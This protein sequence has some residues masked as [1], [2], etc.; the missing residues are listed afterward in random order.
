[1]KNFRELC[2]LNMKPGLLF[3]SDLLY[4]LNPKE[5]ALL[6]DKSI[7]VVIDLRNKDEVERL[8]DTNIKAIT[9]INNPLLPESKEGEDSPLKTVTIKHM[10]LPDMDNAYRELVR[11]DR[12]SA[13]SNIFN[14]LLSTDG[15]VLYHCSAGKDRTGVLSAV[16]LTALGIDKETIYKDYL[17][18]NEKP[19]Y[20]K[21][22][23]LEMD[24]ESREIFLDYFQAKK[25]YLDASFDEINKIYGSFDKFLLECCLIDKNKL[26][27]LKDKYLKA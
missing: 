10:T 4:H 27:I 3:R 26:D 5:K 6:R 17:L 7:K 23:A 20:Y 13:W 2:Y 19:L 18:T 8:K 11:R 21:K 1:M 22:L 16:I 25:E 9:F 12:Q 15:A 14:I 24:S